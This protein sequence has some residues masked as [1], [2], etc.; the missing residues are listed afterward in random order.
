MENLFFFL[1]TSFVL[2][3]ANPRFRR[4]VI[5]P[6][7]SAL[8]HSSNRKLHI[9]H[10]RDGDKLFFNEYAEDGVTYGLIGVQMPA[11]HSAAE[12]EKILKQYI[13]RVRHPLK[14]RS[15]VSM[16]TVR[17]ASVVTVEDYWQDEAGFDWKIKGHTNGQTLALLYVKNIGDTTVGN[18]DAFLNGVRFSFV[19]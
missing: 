17:S 3:M 9:R 8:L 16:E 15:Y 4:F 2:R 18:H 12:A 10:T 14:I 1:A 13:S 7:F 6:G 11:F 5:C 19:S